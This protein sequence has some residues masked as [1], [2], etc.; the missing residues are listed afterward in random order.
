MARACCTGATL[1][2][3]VNFQK[4]NLTLAKAQWQA[5]KDNLPRGSIMTVEIG[6]EP[7]YYP[8]KAG[9]ER[10]EYL[11]C[12]FVG[13]WKRFAQGM[14]CKEITSWGGKD[15]TKNLFCG[16]VWGHINMQPAY[17]DWF[18]RLGW[19]SAVVRGCFVGVCALQGV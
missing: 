11:S 17:L 7:D 1:I 14:S 4:E 19:W 10:V 2:L 5:A 3:G 9:K 18:L 8:I 13:D 12:C 16:P 6:N 15:C